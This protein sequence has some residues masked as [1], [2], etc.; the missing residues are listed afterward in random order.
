M[1]LLTAQEAAKKLRMSK[2]TFLKLGLPASQVSPRKFLYREED[3]DA[4]TRSRLQCPGPTAGE[5]RPQRRN[6]GKILQ[7][8]VPKVLSPRELMNLSWEGRG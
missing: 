7:R 5:S 4:Y 1:N 6:K 3:L 2:R 8:G